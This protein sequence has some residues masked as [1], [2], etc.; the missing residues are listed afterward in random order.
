[1]KRKYFILIILILLV[2]MPL[3]VFYCNWR[4][5]NVA[6]GKL[7]SDVRRIPFNKVGLLLG[8]SK[9]LAGGYINPY[10]SYR[11]QAAIELYKAGKIQYIIV[12]G[13]NGSKSYNEPET[14]QKDLI[15][16]GVDS[17]HIYLDYAGFRTFD[18][19]I[20][21][22]DVFGQNRATII[23]QPFHNERALYIASRE[24]ITAVGF[25]ARDVNAKAGFRTQV[26]ERLA[27]V[28]VFVDYLTGTD[29]KFLGPKVIIP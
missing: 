6:E 15:E 24:G 17:S 22:R 11:V 26:R 3:L 25:N 27:R 9:Y 29:P 28:K 10:Y 16:G 20:R 12:S 4:V 14:F 8:T 5:E 21:L 23:S 1:M 13:D 2:S 7:Y 18:S 19:M